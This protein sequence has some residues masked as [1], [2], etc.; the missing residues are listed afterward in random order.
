[1]TVRRWSSARPQNP[2]QRLEKVESAPGIA[3]AAGLAARSGGL[4]GATCGGA[5]RPECGALPL[6]ASPSDNRPQNLA[7]HH[8]S[9][10]SAPGIAAAAA[11][12]ARSGGL[13]GATRRGAPRPEGGALPLAA[14]PGDTRPQNPSQRLEKIDSAPGIAAAAASPGANATADHPPR[15]EERRGR[16]RVSKDAPAPTNAPAHWIILRQAQDEVLVMTARPWSSARPENP[17]QHLEKVDSAPGIAAAAAA[18]SPGANRPQ[19]PPADLVL[20]SGAVGGASRRALQRAPASA[21]TGTPFE[22]PPRIKVR[23]SRSPQDEAG[24]KYGA[25]L[26]RDNRSEKRSQPLEKVDSAPGIATAAAVARSGGL[27]DATRRRAMVRPSRR[28]PDWRHAVNA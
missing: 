16:R 3:T 14:S 15:P 21:P 9:V 11:V 2:P 25:R 1:M 18:A 26:G 7:Q 24:G 10:E 4:R 6:A 22:T 27:R 23:G 8:D 20:R 28:F 12:A 19:R 13:R 5:P 17:P